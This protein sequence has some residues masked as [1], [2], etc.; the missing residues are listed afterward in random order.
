MTTERDTHQVKTSFA[1]YRVLLVAY[2]KPQWRQAILLALLLLGSI[3]LRLINPRILSGFIDAAVEGGPTRGLLD[4]ALLFLGVALL[5]QVISV[6]ETYVATNVGLTVTNQLRA[7]L[8]LHCLNLDMSFHNNRT[9]GELIERVDGDVGKL[10]NFFSRFIIE[11]LGNGVLMIGILIVLFTIDWRAGLALSIFAIAT[12]LLINRLRDV[13]VPHYRKARQ[14]SA[15][16]MGFLEERLSGTEDVRANGA[17]AYVMRRLYERSRL[18]LRAWVKASAIGMGSFGFTMI[19]FAVGTTISLA[20]GAYLHR[21]D[22]ITIGTVYLI[23]RYTELLNTPIEQINRQFQDLQQAGASIV[24]IQDLLSARSAIHDDGQATLPTGKA[25]AI[26]FENVSF[27]YAPSDEQAES[28]P[29]IVLQDISFDLPPG[30]VLGLLGRTG[31]GKTTLT[32]LLLRLY[33][34]TQGALRLSGMELRDVRLPALRRQ[35]GMVTQEIQLFNASLRDNL[36]L[37]D[38]AIPDERVLDALQE[39]GLLDWFHALPQ[40]LD[41]KL[42]PGGSGLSAGEAQLLAFARVFLRDPG[43]VIL[44]EASSRLDPATEQRLERA[45]DQLLEGRTG[46]IIAH[47]LGTVQRAD[48]IMILENGRQIEYGEREHL[49]R[50]PDSHFAQLLETGLQEALA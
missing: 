27:G 46:I 39:L 35:V 21:L 49:A 50:D 40:G 9:P 7:D 45:V 4:G 29:D 48:R 44:D 14:T 26:Q 8:T 13:A 33:D 10:G 6:V 25:L 16:L 42:A 15:D 34:P 43:L 31:S 28:A 11:I 37:F 30:T 18:V 38:P 19:L 17:V 12:L 2:F 23:F 3:G 41:T 32:R 24:R 22:L 5:G 36:T 1:Q 47:R 20:L